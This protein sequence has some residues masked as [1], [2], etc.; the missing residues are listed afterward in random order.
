MSTVHTLKLISEIKNQV[1]DPSVGSGHGHSRLLQLVDELKLAV[2]TPTETILRLIY[3]LPENAALR[4]VVDL[5]IFPLLVNTETKSGVSATDLARDT[6][7][8]RGLIVRLMRM[9]TALGLCATLEPEKYI[10]TDKS[11]S[12]IHPIGRDGVRCIFDLT[13]PTLSKLPEYFQRHGYRNPQ[14]YSTSPMKWAVGKS[15]FEWLAENRLHQ[16]LF[17][18]Y[19]SSRREGRPNWFC[20]YPIEQLMAGAVVSPDAVFL[21]PGRLILQDLPK[22]ISS[23]EREGIE[24][25]SYSFLDPQPI[26]GACAYCFRAIFHDWPDRMCQKILMNTVSAMKPGYSRVII[27][28]FVL[29]D[30]NVPR[31]QA[32]MDIQMMSIGAGVER[33]EQQWRELLLNA[34]LKI[35]G[36][37]NVS[38]NMESIIEAVP[39]V[40]TV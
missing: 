35:I 9:M 25:I 29:P 36:I 1:L 8:D 31:M 22:I 20:I 19:M 11:S 2:E 33:S 34:G 7:G 4:T 6:G 40:D 21:P 37:W 12:M 5:G 32:A 26:K 28:D 18:S 23:V 17:N 3:Q 38:P 13:V 16:D 27:I 15:Q 39:V 14:E 10:A 30:T 24:K